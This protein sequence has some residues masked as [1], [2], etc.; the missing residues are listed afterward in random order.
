MQSE[1]G[2][3]RLPLWMLGLAV[4]GTIGATGVWGVRAGGGF[5]LG[6]L[7]AWVNLRLLVRAVDRIG[8]LALDGKTKN[9][10][11]GRSGVVVFI[12]LM[13]LVLGAF[14]I[15]RFS[16]FNKVAV[17][18]GFLVCPAAVILEILYELLKY[19]HS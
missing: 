5:L 17:L 12:Q 9:V 19:E 2:I 18:C 4:V 16:G 6:S 8:R 10:R 15:L 7:G 1:A 14:V 3:A 11:P 13:A